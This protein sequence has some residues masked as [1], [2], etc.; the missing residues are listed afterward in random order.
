VAEK[1]KKKNHFIKIIF[2][3]FFDFSKYVFEQWVYLHHMT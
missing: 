2:S 3:I 1:D